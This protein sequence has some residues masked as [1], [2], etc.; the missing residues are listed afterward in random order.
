VICALQPGC[1]DA[2]DAARDSK[3]PQAVPISGLFLQSYFCKAIL[4]SYFATSLRI[5]SSIL[6]VLDLLKESA[7]IL[8]ISL[9]IDVLLDLALRLIFLCMAGVNRNTNLTCS[10]SAISQSSIA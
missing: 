9:F 4:Q 5:S 6:S 7:R 3:G 8:V 10:S 1:P 2:D